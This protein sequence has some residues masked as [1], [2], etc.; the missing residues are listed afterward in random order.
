[1]DGS[2]L[3]SK[4]TD[5]NVNLILKKKTNTFSETSW[6]MLNQMSGYRGLAIS[7]CKYVCVCVCVCVCV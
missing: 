7:F 6:I 1:M 5:L 4:S 3:Y 2:L